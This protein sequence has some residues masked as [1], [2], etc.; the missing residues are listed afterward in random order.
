MVAR[1]Q[2]NYL[3]TYDCVD[4]VKEMAFRC[5]LPYMSVPMQTT[6]LIRKE[7]L[8]ISNDFSWLGQDN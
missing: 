3:M 8:L 6:H 5:S 2:G 1:I 7:E 4:E